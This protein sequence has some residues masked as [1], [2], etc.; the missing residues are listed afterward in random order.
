M[1]SLDTPHIEYDYKVE[2]GSLLASD[3]KSI[4]LYS[5]LLLV[6][7]A[8]VLSK[9]HLLLEEIIRVDY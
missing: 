5:S 4:N 2:F 6:I 3:V 8:M 9:L 7:K 1:Y